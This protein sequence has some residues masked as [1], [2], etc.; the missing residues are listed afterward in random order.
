MAS[1]LAAFSQ[2]LLVFLSYALKVKPLWLTSSQRLSHVESKVVAHESSDGV[3]L[4][5][6]VAGNQGTKRLADNNDL[7]YIL[8]EDGRVAAEENALEGK[9]AGVLGGGP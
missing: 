4:G 1:V 8:Q 6:F 5:S 7:V 2:S 9:M 3:D